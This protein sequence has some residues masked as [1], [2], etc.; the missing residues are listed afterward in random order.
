MGSPR[1]SATG[2]CPGQAWSLSRCPASRLTDRTSSLQVSWIFKGSATP[3]P[4]GFETQES[5]HR[6]ARDKAIRKWAATSCWTGQR[7]VQRG[8]RTAQASR[9]S[10]PMEKPKLCFVSV[11]GFG[12]G[13]H[14]PPRGGDEHPRAHTHGMCHGPL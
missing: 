14:P 8:V 12:L 10:V 13:P 9:A 2:A 1:D 6:W 4:L 3:F 11:I 5:G 7:A